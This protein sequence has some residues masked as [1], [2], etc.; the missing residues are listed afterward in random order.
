MRPFKREVDGVGTLVGFHPSRIGYESDDY[1]KLFVGRVSRLEDDLAHQID[2]EKG[3]PK[4]GFGY[5]RE[6]SLIVFDNRAEADKV[7]VFNFK[8]DGIGTRVAVSGTYL[9]DPDGKKLHSGTIVEIE[10]TTNKDGILGIGF[11]ENIGGHSLEGKVDNGYGW[12]VNTIWVIIPSDD[13]ELEN[14]KGSSLGLG[15]VIK[16][17]MAE[18]MLTSLSKTNSNRV[19][20]V[21][22]DLKSKVGEDWEAEVRKSIEPKEAAEIFITLLKELEK[23]EQERL[24]FGKVLSKEP[25]P[26]QKLKRK[27]RPKKEKLEEPNETPIEKE[28][29]DDEIG[30]ILDSLII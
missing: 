29:T 18:L 12:R 15:E 17:V 6:D 3:Q 22:E 30:D 23:Q 24:D 1:D 2:L 26:T 16:S 21:I 4:E 10:G 27:G 11:D 5:V 9:P 13:L 7:R 19:N 14:T 20:V 25:I 28:I 8:K